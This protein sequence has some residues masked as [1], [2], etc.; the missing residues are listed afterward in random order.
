MTTHTLHGPGELIAAIPALLGFVPHESVVAVGLGRR[1]HLTLALR[2]DRDDMLMPE[3]GLELARQAASS[4]AADGITQAVVVSFTHEAEP[5]GCVAADILAEAL[6]PVVRAVDVWVCQGDRYFAGG[7]ADAECCPPGGR[8]LPAVPHT[9]NALLES[10][11]S[12]WRA[13]AA[14]VHGPA[15]CAP[16]PAPQVPSAE[17]RRA[18]RAGDR[19]WARRAADIDAW[20]TAALGHL[21]TSLRARATALDLGRAAVALRDVRVRDALILR[22]A[23]AGERAIAD[24]LAGRSTREVDTVLTG[25]L[26][27]PDR[28]PPT[29]AAVRLLA[30]WCAQVAAHARRDDK[31][32]AHA[33]AAVV[34]WWAADAHAAEDAASRALACDP[35]YSLAHLMADVCASGVQ[36]AWAHARD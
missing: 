35:G 7:C 8:V 12:W 23:G 19:S 18:A 2:L 30:W 14:G 6:R 17:R 4:L 24:T 33:L 21:M 28:D 25:A 22:W 5:F 15:A 26:R 34:H 11:R 10:D 3:V 20:R 31:A 16:A 29:A 36:P 1:G 27:D 13:S 32:P 9:V